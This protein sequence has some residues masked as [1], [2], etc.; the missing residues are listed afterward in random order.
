VI[1]V[2]QNVD[3]LHNMAA[4]K[5]QNKKKDQDKNYFE[6]HGNNN[7]LRCDNE[8]CELADKLVEYPENYKTY[9]ELTCLQCKE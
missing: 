9:E 4:E 6:I 1:L 5:S 7:Y 8:K 3:G 2:T